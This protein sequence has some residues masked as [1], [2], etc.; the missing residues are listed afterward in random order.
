MTPTPPRGPGGFKRILGCVFLGPL[1]GAVAVT[2]A[3]WIYE[4]V[5]FQR[6]GNAEAN[7]TFALLSPGFVAF[8][9][10]AGML[11]GL[12]AGILSALV[13]GRVRHRGLRTLVVA[14]IG[15]AATLLVFGRL[16]A[17]S[18]EPDAGPLMLAIVGLAGA[19]ASLAGN[20]LAE[21][22]PARLRPAPAT[23]PR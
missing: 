17:T 7:V 1:V 16:A 5:R 21:R 14:A 12:L 13:A 6:F 18:L 3:I 19:L 2:A 9:Y 15:A 4:A 23:G 10:V 8:G 20:A 22:F 11:P